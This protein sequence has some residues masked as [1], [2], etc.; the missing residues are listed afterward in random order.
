MNKTNRFGFPG[1]SFRKAKDTETHEVEVGTIDE[2]GTVFVLEMLRNIFYSRLS[3]M[4]AKISDPQGKKLWQ[5]TDENF[6]G[7]GLLAKAGEATVIALVDRGS[8]G[9]VERVIPLASLI[10]GEKPDVRQGIVLK[11]AAADFLG[12]PVR[13]SREELIVMRYDER[14]QEE[15]DRARIETEVEAK[16]MEKNRQRMERE[17][18]AA[19]QAQAAAERDAAKK[20][21]REERIEK[22]CARAVVYA[23][24]SD[25]HKHWGIPVLESEWPSL[26]SAKRA[27]LVDS[28][29]EQTG[30]AGKSLQAFMV[31]KEPGRNPYKRFL[32]TVFS[33]AP[34]P[35]E[36]A[37]AMPKPVRTILI[38]EKGQV[39]KVDVYPSTDAVRLARSRGLNGG[40]YV[41]VDKTDKH[42]RHDVF[43][44]YKDRMETVGPFVPIG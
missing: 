18:A 42:G 8:R 43:R 27:I 23:Y 28:F 36:N 9:L 25:G 2:G 20:A 26:P 41:T 39:R 3:F 21:A 31:V 1:F 40:S 34:V 32:V 15:A 24:T 5:F 37:P 22:L 10:S 11:N 19:A 6:D 17:A 14:C 12:R 44:A 33:E 4:V 38:D 35:Q 30:E 29:N 7:L 13:F 16:R